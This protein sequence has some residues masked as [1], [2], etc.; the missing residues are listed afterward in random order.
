MINIEKNEEN[1]REIY[2]TMGGLPPKKMA[3][4]C[5]RLF[6]FT[7]RLGVFAVKQGRAEARPYS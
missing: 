4:K 3:D 7:L 5:V 6:I 2:Y 1:C